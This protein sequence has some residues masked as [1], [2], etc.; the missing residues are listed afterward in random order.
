M[1]YYV[2][3][4]FDPKTPAFTRW[5][6]EL[7]QEEKRRDED[8]E[9]MLPRIDYKVVLKDKFGQSPDEIIFFTA[10]VD[11]ATGILHEYEKEL[12]TRSA[13]DFYYKMVKKRDL[14]HFHNFRP[15]DA[16]QER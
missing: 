6:V 14:Q 4:S 7:K 15:P 11:K 13:G 9:N 16:V 8:D 2:S 1:A 10:D 3:T 12:R 5:D